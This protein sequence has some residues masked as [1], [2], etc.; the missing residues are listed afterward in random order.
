MHTNLANITRIQTQDST[1]AA[2]IGDAE[3]RKV[4]L[5]TQLGLLEKGSQAILHD[6]GKVEVD[7]SEDSAQLI[8]RELNVKRNQLVELSAKYT[9]NYPDVV[10]LRGEVEE[11][12]KKLTA[13]PVSVRSSNDQEKNISKSR[14]YLPLSGR[15]MQEHRNLKAQMESVSAEINALKRQRETLRRS[16]ISLQAKIDQA[17]RRDQE[18]ITVTRDYDNLKNLYNELQRKKMEANMSQ[19][20]EMRQKGDQFQILDPANL[21]KNPFRPNPASIFGLSFLMAIALGFGGAI[22]ME[23]M[24]LSLRGVTDFKH[25]FDIPVLAT[26]PI[27]ETKEGGHRENLRRKAK[28]GGIVSVACA[29]FA[30]LLFFAIKFN[31]F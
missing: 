6:D 1:I 13:I 26:I 2:E 20:L 22:G 3:R 30:L 7:T 15:E 16:I 4:T 11:L 18:M 12:E 8:A 19:D 14:T 25:F 10:R 5:Q 21:P 24:D 27:L 23:K 29:I 9:D 28:I 31:I 17:P